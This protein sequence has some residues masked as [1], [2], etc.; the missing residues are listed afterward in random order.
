MK[1]LHLTYPLSLFPNVMIFRADQIKCSLICLS[2]T[3]RKLYRQDIMQSA[4][5]PPKAVEDWSLPSNCIQRGGEL[6]SGPEA[7]CQ[8]SL[9]RLAHSLLGHGLFILYVKINEGTQVT[10][11]VFANN[12]AIKNELNITSIVYTQTSS[13]QIFWHY[14]EILINWNFLSIALAALTEF[15]P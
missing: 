4:M 2:K 9:Y 1:Q 14:K 15:V 7:W 3:H 5:R 8:I 12:M 13:F 10:L 11:K 6:A